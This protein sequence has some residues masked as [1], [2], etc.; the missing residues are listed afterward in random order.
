MADN[1]N[2]PRL[3]NDLFDHV[4]LH[5]TLW[6]RTSAEVR[7]DVVRCVMCDVYVV[8]VVTFLIDF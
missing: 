6:S 4:L 2:I 3:F 1:Q 5:P 8:C 7:F